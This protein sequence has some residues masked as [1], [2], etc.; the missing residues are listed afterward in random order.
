MVGAGKCRTSGAYCV[1]C[2]TCMVA[3]GMGKCQG[4][5]GGWSNAWEEGE[6]ACLKRREG[7]SAQD[8]IIS[9]IITGITITIKFE[10]Y[11]TGQDR[12]RLTIDLPY[13]IC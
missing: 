5:E 8:C 1:I 2:G 6:T 12:C 10:H 3:A 9:I 13:S 11:R 7:N 4:R